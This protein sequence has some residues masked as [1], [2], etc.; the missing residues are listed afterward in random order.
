MTSRDVVIVGGGVIGLSI[1]WRA[2]LLGLD[3]MVVDDR[4]GEAASWAAAGMLAPITEVHFG[5]EP[6]LQLNLA[7]ARRYPSFVTELEACTGMSVD[8]RTCGALNVAFDADDNAALEDLF[9]FQQRLGLQV[10]RLRGSE[11]RQLE[12]M[13]VPGV[14]GGVL[15]EDDNQVN[16][17]LLVR[18]LLDA[19]DRVGG[20]IRREKVAE[21]IV[22]AGRAQGARLE[23]GERV[24]APT[25]VLAAGC[26]SSASFGLDA[27]VCPPVRPIKGQILRL[28]APG[29]APFFAH[30]LR[31]LVRGSSI[32][33]VS[34]SDG[35]V[36]V[37]ATMEEQSFDTRV[38]VEG[39]YTLLRDIYQLLP[40]TADLELV[41]AR[42]ALRPGSPDN[43]PLL[44]PTELP[45]LVMATGHYR[46]GILL[47]PITADTIASLLAT[48][49]PPDIITPF[50]PQR[51]SARVPSG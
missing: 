31:A 15:A 4:P 42:A 46:N 18:A 38:T 20:S 36:V 2:A 28:Q 24:S 34:R 30:T 19:V 10:R 23:S 37:G 33:A 21:I 51:F 5:E 41:E 47:T 17:R 48:G 9:R 25:V 3:V 45:G 22:E 12:P 29:N 50:S 35:E 7:S 43:A 40:G 49:T 16:N 6:L 8:Y 44:G 1:A 32:Y 11:C 26:W 27:D 14:R 13:L 39:T